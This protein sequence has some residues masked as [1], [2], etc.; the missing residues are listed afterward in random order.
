MKCNDAFE[1]IVEAPASFAQASTSDPA[2]RQIAADF[3]DVAQQQIRPARRHEPGLLQY[4][5]TML[6]PIP[7]IRGDKGE[8]NLVARRG[9]RNLETH[10]LRRH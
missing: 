4:H 6:K 7:R 8:S 10:V 2:I 5:T 1:F 9:C 3:A